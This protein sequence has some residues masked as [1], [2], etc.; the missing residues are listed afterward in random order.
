[1][2]SFKNF[3]GNG[4]D[5]KPNIVQVKLILPC[6]DS[7]KNAVKPKHIPPLISVYSFIFA[8]LACKADICARLN[9]EEIESLSFESHRQKM[10]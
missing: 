3:P 2:Y 8:D 6:T 1:M 5:F 10:K 9:P 4:Y 7:H